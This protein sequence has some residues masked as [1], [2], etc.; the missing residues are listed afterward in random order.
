MID[1]LALVVSV[2]A[3]TVAVV[4]WRA[5][6]SVTS[7]NSTPA[8]PRKVKRFT[9]TPAR[10]A[11]TDMTGRATLLP[12]TRAALQAEL[13]AD[14]MGLGYETHGQDYPA[15]A[16]LLN[17]TGTMPNPDAQGNVPR[18]L[19][20][21]D[22]YAAIQ[23]AEALQIYQLSALKDDVETVLR[24]NDRTAMAALLSIVAGLLSVESQAAIGGLLEAT[25]KDPDWQATV[26]TP[27]RAAVLG[28]LPI[29]AAQVQDADN[30]LS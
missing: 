4:G 27:S 9:A 21:L 23:P 3:L 30:F 19:G 26:S 14:P 16:A 8:L 28:W 5:A 12:P 1:L 7:L 25:E 6:R 24:A 29:T 17:A 18:R 20:M 2:L 22:L 15:I 11:P 10:P 13:A